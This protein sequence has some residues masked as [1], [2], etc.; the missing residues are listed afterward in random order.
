M[1]TQETSPYTL[2]MALR[3]SSLIDLGRPL[4]SSSLVPDEAWY[5]MS[6][7]NH[8]SIHLCI[9]IYHIIPDDPSPCAAARRVLRHGVAMTRSHRLA[10]SHS[11]GAGAGKAQTR[12]C[13][14]VC[15][16]PT[17]LAGARSGWNAAGNSDTAKL[18]LL[19]EIIN[20]AVANMR[21]VMCLRPCCCC[22]K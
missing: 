9:H 16:C 19:R 5:T 14:C 7:C 6:G 12:E 18:Q 22:C 4:I 2:K 20:T 15:V 17:W 1:R 13:H 21:L 3:Y 8:I 10:R 11:T